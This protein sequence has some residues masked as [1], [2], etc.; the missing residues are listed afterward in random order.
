MASQH[1]DTYGKYLSEI[2]QKPLLTDEEEITLGR[3]VQAY[4]PLRD[5]KATLTEELGRGPTLD[6]WAE[7]TGADPATIDRTVKVGERAFKRMTEANLRLVCAVAKKY[8]RRNVEI[9]DLVQE[10]NLGLAR[11][12]EKFDPGKGYRF[13]TYA[14]WW[15]RQAMTR[16]IHNDSRQIRLPIHVSETLTMAKMWV[17]K[18]ISEQGRKPTREELVIYLRGKN[19]LAPSGSLEDSLALFDWFVEMN[20]PVGSLNYVA[21]GDDEGNELLSFMIAEGEDPEDYVMDEE[22]R[23]LTE[24]LIK[25]LPPQQRRVIT[26]RFGLED[27][28]ALTLA[29]IG[30]Q[31]GISRERVRQIQN[32]AMRNLKRDT[33]DSDAV[34]LLKT[35]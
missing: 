35:A 26:L 17:G 7:A 25:Q 3:Q 33:R 31:M 14:Y 20:R 6:E 9:L 13:S 28:K 27:G 22:L 19:K 1:C 12:V 34:E 15:I 32:L 10:G 18:F 11:A 30:R 29:Q 8:M 2:A 21:R 16:T 24:G 23:G 4:V 5:A